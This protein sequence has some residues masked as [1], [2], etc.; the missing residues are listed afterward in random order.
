MNLIQN[1]KNQILKREQFWLNP[2]YEIMK[3]K[4]IWQQCPKCQC[5]QWLLLVSGSQVPL[6]D[7]TGASRSWFTTVRMRPSEWSSGPYL[8]SQKFYFCFTIHWD[9]VKKKKENSEIHS[10]IDTYVLFRST[11]RELKSWPLRQQ[12]LQLLLADWLVL[13][14]VPDVKMT[15]SWDIIQSTR[16]PQRYLQVNSTHPEASKPSGKVLAAR[17]AGNQAASRSPL[18]LTWVLGCF[19]EAETVHGWDL[20]SFRHFREQE[21]WAE[22]Q[23]FSKTERYVSKALGVST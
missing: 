8:A 15:S 19:W 18:S 11:Q 5:K 17:L 16:W 1:E 9:C 4:S 7:H 6:A 13:P 12:R 2:E 23:V 3:T 21:T 20:T 10:K 22:V 14:P